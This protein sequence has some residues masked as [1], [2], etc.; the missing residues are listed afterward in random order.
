MYRERDGFSDVPIDLREYAEKRL[1]KLEKYFDSPE[2]LTVNVVVKPAGVL[3]NTQ[4]EYAWLA[5]QLREEF[6][7]PSVSQM[8][9]IVRMWETFL[10]NVRAFDNS[11]KDMGNREYL[12]NH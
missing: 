12:V 4:Q 2:D 5:G 1:T 3:Q 7:T 8:E 9:S 11:F 6:E 10:P